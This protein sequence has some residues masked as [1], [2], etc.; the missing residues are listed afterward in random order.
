MAL[1]HW[2]NPR[3]PWRSFHNHG[4]IRLVEYLSLGVLP[5]GLVA[6]PTEFIIGGEPAPHVEVREWAYPLSVTD[7]TL[8]AGR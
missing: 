2:P 1:H 7:L 8:I 6:R 4:I 5:A 3:V